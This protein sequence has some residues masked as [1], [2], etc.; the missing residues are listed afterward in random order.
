MRRARQTPRYD[1]L[2]H[3][4]YATHGDDVETTI[5]NGQVL[6]HERKMLTLDEAAVLREG[7]AFAV[8]VRAAVATEAQ[9]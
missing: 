7:E 9:R 6:M 8:R 3:L 2:S 5:V 1:A 4:V